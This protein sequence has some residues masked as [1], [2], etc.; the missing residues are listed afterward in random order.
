MANLGRDVTL[1]VDPAT[2]GVTAEAVLR[3]Y[4][5]D[6]LP[7]LHL[8]VLP[9][10]RT[11]GSIAYRALFSAWVA[12]GGGIALA[13]SKKH[14]REAHARLGRY[15]TLVVEAHEVDSLQLAASGRDGG[16]MRQLES[17]VLKAASAVVCNA[18]GTLALLRD[19]HP[20]LP[21]ALVAHNGTRCTPFPAPHVDA[22]GVG[23]VGSVRAYKDLETL[24]RAAP[25]ISES[26]HLV[27]AEPT[28]PF[29][30]ALAKMAEGALILEPP[31]AYRH[32]P[33]RMSRFRVLVV[34]AAKGL[35]GEQLTSPLKLWDALASG[36]VVVAADTPAMRAAAGAAF[37]P[38]QP[39]DAGDLVAAVEMALGNEQ[40]RESAL[41]AATVRTWADRARELLA[42]V[43][44]VR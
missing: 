20:V 3:F 33:E 10:S 5:L 22:H 19:V 11:A 7:T 30:H 12:Q 38:Y 43:E 6:P 1:A 42:F 31:L 40:R 32:V 23:Y 24:A 15:F 14:A 4:G 21:P 28:D 13:R 17:E 2:G 9:R 25:Q 27:G 29:A 41:E 8:H 26:V 37:I 36:V 39:A 16:P 44:S 34:P 35:F 18:P